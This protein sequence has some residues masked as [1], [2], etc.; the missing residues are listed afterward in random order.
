MEKFLFKKIEIW[1]LLLVIVFLLIFT[2][3]FGSLVLRSETARN[4]AL[5]PNNIKKIISGSDLSVGN[6]FG[7][8]S[9]LIIYDKNFNYE[10]KYLLLSRYD[11][12][13]QRS[14]VELIN[15]NTGEIIHTWKPD[16]NIIIN[17]L[18]K[19]D[20]IQFK[21]D[22]NKKRY[23]IKFPYLT[24]DGNLYV[25]SHYTPLVKIDICSKFLKSI[26]K[27]AHH[28]IEPDENGIWFPSTNFN[29]KN[30]PGLDLKVN[31][32]KLLFYDD[33]ITK[34]DF[35][36]NIVFD[37]SVIEILVENGLSH[38]IFS[39][40]P[41]TYDPLHLNDVQPVLIDGEYFKK[42]DLFLNF[43]HT[44][45]VM[46]YRPSI[47]KILWYK[48]FP[49]EFQHDVDILDSNR[50]SVYNNNRL[51]N[52]FDKTIK[53]NNL[54]IYNFSTDSY[55]Y[56]QNDIFKQYDIRTITMGAADIF[57]DGSLFVMEHNFGRLL[58]FDK[59]KKLLWEYINKSKKNS[60]SYMTN[61]SRLV[62]FNKKRFEEKLKENNFCNIQ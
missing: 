61:G 53:N 8:K 9:G 11:G 10:K 56:F 7:D 27:V 43:R 44:S 24:S 38:L 28:T 34:I 39:G 40:K 45:M 25:K 13:L 32:E 59:D 42:G 1:I 57:K 18:K 51:R 22:H 19:N 29:S 62:N 55:E 23:Q 5:I 16:I 2:I 31:A 4:I 20:S 30:N 54:I 35:E 3:F 21:R 47:N 49:W 60:K 50:I 26:D 15:L 52:N 58:M 12:D 46:L 17:N 14:L 41:S 33:G 48:Q 6:R 36:D 37:K